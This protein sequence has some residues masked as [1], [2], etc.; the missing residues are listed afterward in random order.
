MSPLPAQEAFVAWYSLLHDRER[1]L[2][3]V[4]YLSV[5]VKS[6]EMAAY[7]PELSQYCHAELSRALLA[8]LLICMGLAFCRFFWLF[9][10][11]S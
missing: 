3:V 2:L 10:D 1:L 4:R 9:S 7:L 11:S 6:F 5:L 8:G